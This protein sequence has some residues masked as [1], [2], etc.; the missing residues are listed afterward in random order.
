M[1]TKL[2]N[3]KPI[4]F[5]EIQGEWW[6]VG[7]DAA[8]VLEYADPLRAIQQHVDKEDRKALSHKVYGDSCSN[9]WKNDNDFRKKTVI[10]EFGIYDLI[11]NSKM[12]QAKNFKRWTFNILRKLRKS[13]GLE[14]Y[15][16]F[17][18]TEPKIQNGLMNYLGQATNDFRPQNYIKANVVADKA[19]SNHFGLKKMIKKNQ[20]T[21]QMLL[22]RR[23]V[24]KDVVDLMAVQ[25][26]YGL[27]VSISKTIYKKAEKKLVKE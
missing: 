12:P 6:A 2:W 22:Y 17:K 3:G 27:N 16:V 9:L 26:K 23:Q 15:E 11:F 20:M 10:S 21:P 14:G 7:K 5:I 1:E 25:S 4:R 24:L 19:V 8:A 13:A 18:M